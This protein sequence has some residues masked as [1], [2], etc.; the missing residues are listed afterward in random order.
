[1]ADNDMNGSGEG[2]GL[3]EFGG[4]ISISNSIVAF[5]TRNGNL[6]SDIVGTITS[7]GYNN[8]R[9]VQPGV[10]VGDTTGNITGTG[11]AM[12]TLAPNGGVTMTHA[13]FPGSIGID[14][15]DPD[16]CIRFDQ[17]HKFRPYDG[18]QNG[19]ERCDMGAYEFRGRRG[20]VNCDGL[21]DGRDIQAFVMAMLDPALYSGTFPGC[22]ITNADVNEDGAVEP[23][24]VAAFVPLLTGG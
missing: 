13:L 2:G 7:G 16:T 4:T 9:Q 19:V 10:I 5:N 12:L 1:M 21:I 24:D 8:V 11:A 22:E 17:R 20:D 3:A 18:D 15:A 14:A 6:R 23:A